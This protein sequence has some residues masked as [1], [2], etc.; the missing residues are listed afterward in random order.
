[1]SRVVLIL[2][3]FL[4]G[5]WCL[6]GLHSRAGAEEA[7]YSPLCRELEKSG[8]ELLNSGLAYGVPYVEIKVPLGASVTSICKRVPSLRADFNRCRDKISFFN[9]LHPLYIKNNAREP[10]SLEADILKIPLDRNLVPEIFPAADDALASY[11]KFILVD[12]GKGFLA[13]YT[14]GE[15]QRVF[16]ISGGTPEKATPLI[17]F[18]IAKKEE[19][20]WSNIYDTWMPWALLIK[21]PYYIHGGALP[22]RSDSAGCIRMFPHDAEELYHLVEVGTPGRIIETSPLELTY[23]AFFCR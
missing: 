11:D 19:E 3:I 4:A 5:F 12:I 14:Q 22:G 16:P 18:K 15:L 6:L 2:L 20:H 17:N 23:P 8:L 13:L 7:D 9:A 10:F 21:R 1:M